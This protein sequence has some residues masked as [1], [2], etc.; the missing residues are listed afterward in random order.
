MFR[1][2]KNSLLAL[3]CAVII[4]LS[5]LCGCAGK[6]GC[7][8]SGTDD[9]TAL[10]TDDPSTAV[11]TRETDQTNAPTVSPDE[12]EIPAETA[13]VNTEIPGFTPFPDETPTPG[14]PDTP[15]PATPV[16]TVPPSDETLTGTVWLDSFC[17]VL[18]DLD[19]DGK[20][21]RIEIKKIASG[22][23]LEVTVG[24]GGQKLM[25]EL[26]ADSLLSAVI[27]DFNRG[28]SRAELIVSVLTG[29]RGH[30]LY[31]FRLNGASNGFETC[32]I[33]GRA[34]S[35][36]GD[37]LTVCRML[38]VMGT[39]DCT[40]LFVFS[41]SRFELNKP[42]Q[43]WTVKRTEERWCTVSRDMLVGLYTTG[44]DN[45]TTFLE[46]GYRLYP[47]STDMESIINLTLDTGAHGYLT[48][49]IGPNGRP[50][51]SGSDLTEWFSDLTFI[52]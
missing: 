44:L 9:P 40:A 28:D 31:C 22:V 7:A 24:A 23:S 20:P 34:E 4:L 18:Y 30:K 10:N 43:L 8:P 25:E 29:T 5:V 38:D 12:T 17:S 39:W 50:L 13:S 32:S 11:P 45:E 52:N 1:N 15:A 19:L 21:E 47:T 3:L 27:S 35:V 14:N 41:N 37:S 2:H 26:T 16:P 48:I 51:I 46:P 49:T 6:N 42:S 33:D 36:D